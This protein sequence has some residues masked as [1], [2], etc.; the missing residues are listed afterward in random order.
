ML[1]NQ[2][3]G[4]YVQRLCREEGDEAGTGGP[5]SRPKLI[6]R[7]RWQLKD[8]PGTPNHAQPFTKHY[9]LLRREEKFWC[10]ITQAE[11]GTT[12]LWAGKGFSRP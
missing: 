5:L 1:K 2:E 12:D 7:G 8:R 3:A 11:L 6:V 4:R 9:W 10:E